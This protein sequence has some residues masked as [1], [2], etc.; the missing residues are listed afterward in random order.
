MIV[1]A[2]IRNLGNGAVMTLDPFVRGGTSVGPFRFEFRDGAWHA[3]CSRTVETQ[4]HWDRTDYEV[5]TSDATPP[6]GLVNGSRLD[7]GTSRFV[8]ED[9]GDHPGRSEERAWRREH[10]LHDV[11]IDALSRKPSNEELARAAQTVDRSWPTSTLMNHLFGALE[12][13][14]SERIRLGALRILCDAGSR[15]DPGRTTR[16]LQHLS[17]DPKPAIAKCAAG[18]LG[19]ASSIER[20]E[21]LAAR[22]RA[23]LFAA[24]DRDTLR[25]HARSLAGIHAAEIMDDVLRDAL[26]NARDGDRDHRTSAATVLAVFAAPRSD[27]RRTLEAL[28]ADPEPDVRFAVVEEC[29]MLAP[30]I[31]RPILERA[32]TLPL[33]RRLTRQILS[34][35]PGAGAG[36]TES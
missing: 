36:M 2:R 29:G 35:V 6:G 28:L 27:A 31:A 22:L 16:Q 24:G 4:E 9:D 30:E 17:H 10:E 8:F 33:L 18:A 12:P 21:E 11:Y 13:K 5:V 23:E 7:E 26:S 32:R 15:I 34:R 1:G 25:N 3:E 20:A 19:A 14:L